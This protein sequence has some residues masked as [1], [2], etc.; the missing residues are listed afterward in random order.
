MKQKSVLILSLVAFALAGCVK[1]NPI[2]SSSPISSTPTSDVSSSTYVDPLANKTGL[3]L[4]YAIFGTYEKRNVTIDQFGVSKEY[5]MEKAYYIEYDENYASFYN[6]LGAFLYNHGFIVNPIQGVY[7]FEMDD[8]FVKVSTLESTQT[9]SDWL[10]GYM[11]NSPADLNKWAIGE[12]IWENYDVNHPPKISKE[13]DSSSSSSLSLSSPIKKAAEDSSNSADELPK[14]QTEEGEKELDKEA[15]AIFYSTDSNVKLLVG[16]MAGLP[17]DQDSETGEY[18]TDS[19][20]YVKARINQDNTLSFSLVYSEDLSAAKFNITDI[21]TTKGPGMMWDFFQASDD[22]YKGE[23]Y[24]DVPA[25][26]YGKKAKDGWTE[27]E[28]SYFKRNYNNMVLPFPNGATYAM[29]T[30]S[31]TTFAA[32]TD[33]ACGDITSS[34]IQQLK[35]DGWS[36]LDESSLDESAK[37][38]AS[39]TYYK[40]LNAD[41]SKQIRVSFNYS[42]SKYP[43]TDRWNKGTFTANIHRYPYSL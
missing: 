30:Y 15:K 38:E 31:S 21:G 4:L 42:E 20:D 23:A 24:E 34:Y 41:G 27:K 17:F 36:E 5:F 11:I 37:T 18:K 39:P 8:D 22:Q 19:I 32:F 28:I 13:E 12:G 14:D 6:Q 26:Y 25:E 3:D 33:D 7:E 16:T 9:T 43:A 10:Y 29:K 40:N 2:S 35:D 1:E